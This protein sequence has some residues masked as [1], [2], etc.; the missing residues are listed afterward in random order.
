MRV[1]TCGSLQWRRYSS[2]STDVDVVVDELA[3]RPAGVVADGP[4]VWDQVAP[5]LSA[6][7][8]DAVWSSTFQDARGSDLVDD[9][10]TITVPSQLARQRIETR[11][12]G[13]MEAALADAGF[14]DLSLV[15]E[16]EID[17]IRPE[18]EV[19]DLTDGDTPADTA[20]D[21]ADTRPPSSRPSEEPTG[22]RYTFD[23]FVIGPSNRFAHAAALSVAET[24]ARSYNPL[25]IY[26]GAGLG[27]THLLQAI[28]SYVRE[29]YP[30]Y[31]VRYISTETLLNEFVDAIRKNAQPEFKRRYREIDVLLVDDIQFMEGKEQLQEEFFHTFNT[32]HD[33][34][35]QIVLSSDR[36][37]DAIA[38]L[39]DRLRS[40][41]K[42]GLITDIQ[43]PDFETRLAILQKKGEQAGSRVPPDVLNFIA[44]NVTYNIREL[45]GALIRVSAYATLNDTELTVELASEILA[46]TIS[47]TK[48]RQ[49]TP[50]FILE[51]TAAMFGLEIEQLQSKSRTRDLVHARQIGMYVC[52]E[53]TDLSYPQIGKEFGGRDHTTVIHAYEK[54]STRMKDRRKTYE[55]VTSLIQQILAGGQA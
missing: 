31:R 9:V 46:D 19:L 28:A 6:Q 16:V 44:T 48:P 18:F 12:L 47:S 23:S 53:L 14:P 5:V 37:P 51:Q 4:E 39:E 42:M 2:F 43:P 54:V 17:E 52:R 22:R 11:Y 33:A 3:G 26:G 13:L 15:V 10:L 30:G 29:N 21:Q 41:F 34:Q 32:L 36:A 8:S 55:D 1:R 50:A 49:I 25:F 20:P 27:K 38:T 40:R 35:R 7:V 24:P 45:E